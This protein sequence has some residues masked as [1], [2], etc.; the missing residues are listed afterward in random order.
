MFDLNQ[1][2]GVIGE[3]SVTLGGSSVVFK[4]RRPDHFEMLDM[5][6]AELPFE[7]K[8][9][10][11][12]ERFDARVKALCEELGTESDDVAV[13][14]KAHADVPFELSS[15]DYAP[16]LRFIERMVLEID[17]LAVGGVPA[18]WTA[19]T[20]DQ[21][22]KLLRAIPQSD[23]WELYGAI[24]ASASLSGDEKNG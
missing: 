1:L 18:A 14:E 10:E 19:L 21:R 9:R 2:T 23:L 3:F 24:I 11:W 8:R 22:Q 20:G 13:R 6:R 4:Y 5:R 16:R 17:G 7:R 12:R 15:E